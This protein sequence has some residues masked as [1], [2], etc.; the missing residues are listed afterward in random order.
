M[1]KLIT[2]L[3]H[4]LLEDIW[5]K[6]L[7]ETKGFTRFLRKLCRSLVIATHGFFRNQCFLR[8]SALTFYALMSIVPVLA[9]S[10]AVAKGFGYQRHLEM[11]LLQRFPEQKEA[12]EQLIALAQSI[13]ENTKGGLLAFTGI[14]LLFWSV[15]K[16][17]SHIES[18]FNHIWGIKKQRSWIRKFTDYLTLMI[19]TPLFFLLASS[20]T[21]FI[22]SKL[23]DYFQAISIYPLVRAGSL[24][25]VS[26][27]PYAL[28]WMLFS[29][30]YLVMPNT[31]VQV[32]AAVLGGIF[33]GTIFEF[34]QWGYIHFQ[35]G[36]T[37]YSAIYGSFAALP[38]FL[39]WLQI[40]WFIVLYGAEVSYA[41]Q[42]IHFYQY[43]WHAPKLNIKTKLLLSLWIMHQTVFCIWKKEPISRELLQQ[44]LH[45]PME[46]IDEVLSDLIDAELLVEVKEGPCAFYPTKPIDEL[47]IKDVLD[48]L[49]E[50]KQVVAI[51][52]DK[53]LAS[54]Q[55]S[56][57]KFDEM[58]LSCKENCLLKEIEEDAS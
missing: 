23:Q 22:V 47:H 52:E 51:P 1:K 36:I 17:L 46:S 35:I 2:F 45:L 21:V 3:S 16:V 28:I 54:L 42:N 12:L 11:E 14:V 34:L 33:S 4:F 50:K 41:Y 18:S 10:L 20:I 19:L 58:I 49:M 15:I 30:L 8:A 29:L 39:A 25:F 13:V 7:E 43:G 9:I 27:V 26:L 31:K 57:K 38:L 44:K 24:F 5:V 48:A 37:K 32:K 55:H 6:P 56:L 40:S 53:V